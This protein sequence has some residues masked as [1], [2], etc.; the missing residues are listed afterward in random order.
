MLHRTSSSASPHKGR[1]VLTLWESDLSL[2]L[3]LGSAWFSTTQQEG[4]ASLGVPA[5]AELFCRKR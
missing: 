4:H 5:E 1:G 3:R 2:C